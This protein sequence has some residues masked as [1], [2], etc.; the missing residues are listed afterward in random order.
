VFKSFDALKAH[1]IVAIMLRPVEPLDSLPFQ[2]DALRGVLRPCPLIPSYECIGSSLFPIV[3]T[4][5]QHSNLCKP[6]RLFCFSITYRPHRLNGNAIEKWPTILTK[7]WVCSSQLRLQPSIWLP[8]SGN[9][10]SHMTYNLH[11]SHVVSFTIMFCFLRPL[12]RSLGCW[13]NSEEGSN[14]IMQT[15]SKVHNVTYRTSLRDW[16]LQNVLLL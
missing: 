12:K 16:P 5:E 13:S 10:K 3:Y 14:L 4:S 11:A 8:C 15:V 6:N 2:P 1:N 9:S 7:A